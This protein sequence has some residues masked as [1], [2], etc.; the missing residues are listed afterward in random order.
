MPDVT[1][2]IS[3]LALSLLHAVA[4]RSHLAESAAAEGPSDLLGRP[5][6]LTNEAG[7]IVTVEEILE[8][9]AGKLTELT[10]RRVGF[11]LRP[12]QEDGP[13]A[14]DCSTIGPAILAIMAEREAARAQAQRAQKLEWLQI[15][16][17]FDT[18]PLR[19]GAYQAHA[20]RF[21]T[22]ASEL[23][24]RLFPW[25]NTELVIEDNRLRNENARG[26]VRE[27]FRTGMYDVMLVPQDSENRTLQHIYSYSFRVVG[28]VAKVAELEDMHGVINI[29]KVLGEKLLVA[30]D[31]T[32]SRTRVA[33]LFQSAGLD[34]EDGSVELLVD[35]NPSSLR[36]RAETGQGIAIISDEYAAVGGSSRNFPY[37]GLGRRN[38]THQQVHRVDM[39]LLRQSW[40]SKP[41]H[42]ALEFVIEDLVAREKIHPRAAA[43]D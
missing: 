9:I 10:G 38:D 43:Q 14:E 40:A 42:K 2:G 15:A 36:M 37:L 31:K 19:I 3:D 26:I 17:C 13:E 18:T 41:R 12:G 23:M 25:V 29:H 1:P 16:S 28:S 4:E 21:L 8:P 32:S 5:R 22:T 7:Q 24:A 33:K 35:N 20:E 30:P 34:I 27:K 39:C 6:D 11:F